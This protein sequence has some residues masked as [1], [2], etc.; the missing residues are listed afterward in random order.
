MPTAAVENN[1]KT[2]Q[3]RLRSNNKSIIM[4][5]AAAPVI[6]CQPMDEKKRKEAAET[7]M[8]LKS[9][10]SR[11]EATASANDEI[12][13]PKKKRARKLC[14][15]DGCTNYA[16]LGGVCIRHGA[17]QKRCKIDGCTNQAKKGEVC[18]KHGAQLKQC[19]I[20]GCTNIVV[21]GGVCVKHGAELKRCKIE[22][23]TNIVVKGGVCWRHGAKQ[24]P[25]QCSKEGCT[26]IVVKGGAWSG[27]KTQTLYR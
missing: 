26:N 18:V 5:T 22:G 15:A 24:I 16:Q 20:E 7:I 25:K 11:K 19:N 9:K 21:K 27:T 14:S 2:H 17:K 4:P 23:C 13:G 3:R 1:A 6:T 8:E 10:L 12:S